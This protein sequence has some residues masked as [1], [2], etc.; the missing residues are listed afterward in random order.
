MDMNSSSGPDVMASMMSGLGGAGL[1]GGMGGAG[2]G[3]MASM[4]LAGLTA[5]GFKG[6]GMSGGLI[7]RLYDLKQTKDRHET[8]IKDDGLW[9]NPHQCD[10]MTGNQRLA[11]T[12][13]VVRD[14][15]QHHL[16]SPSILNEANLINRFLGGGWDEKVL[17]DYYRSQDP[18]VAYQWSIPLSTAEDV[19]KAFG[20]QNEIKPTHIVIH[21]KGFVTAPRDMTVRF[22][23][24]MRGGV[25]AV[26]FD[27]NNVYLGLHGASSMIDTKP[28]DFKDEYP[29]YDKEKKT[30]GGYGAGKWFRVHAGQKYPV[31]IFITM[32]AGGYGAGL[33]IEEKDP[34]KPYEP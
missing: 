34:S 14:P 30:R 3:G 2:A 10:G 5:F 4:P 29:N 21:Y 18:M 8:N 6:S 31:E 11:F 23:C 33:M 25:M 12:G 22:R 7:G 32:G 24:M 13:K 19:V 28:F 26:R 15:S 20:V 17:L 1:G 16:L 27:N 9:K